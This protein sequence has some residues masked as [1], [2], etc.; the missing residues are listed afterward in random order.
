MAEPHE[1]AAAFIG[2]SRLY[3]PPAGR[4]RTTHCGSVEAWEALLA[5]SREHPDEFWADVA[6]E[7]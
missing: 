6:R 7:L 1:S 3:I 4:A 5:R 2:A